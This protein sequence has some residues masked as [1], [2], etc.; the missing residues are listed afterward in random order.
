MRASCGAEVGAGLV[1]WNILISVARKAAGS[2][3]SDEKGLA[4]RVSSSYKAE[5]Y[6]EKSESSISDASSGWN[7]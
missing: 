6:I 7:V 1:Q 2:K 3:A 5:A 4:E